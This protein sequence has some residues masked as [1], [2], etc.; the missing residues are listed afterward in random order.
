MVDWNARNVK[1]SPQRRSHL[2]TRQ[3]KQQVC[4]E[5]R[6]SAVNMTLPAYATKRRAAAQLLRAA[7]RTPLSIDISCPRRAQQ[8]TRRTLL[9]LLLLMSGQ[10]DGRTDRRAD[11]R[12]TVS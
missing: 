10:T 12:W 5:P 11:G 4:V 8:Q 7:R 2:Y 6:P 9:L 3:L 1:T